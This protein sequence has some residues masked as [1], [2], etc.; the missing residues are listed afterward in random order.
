[1]LHLIGLVLYLHKYW[2]HVDPVHLLRLQLEAVRQSQQESRQQIEQGINRLYL[3]QC[4]NWPVKTSAAKWFGV[5][6]D[7]FSNLYAL[8]WLLLW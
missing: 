1:M 2:Y 8:H 5:L 3:W 6:I 7:T 4:Y